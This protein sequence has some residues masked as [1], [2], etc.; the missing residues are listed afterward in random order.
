MSRL[1]GRSCQDD[2]YNASLKLFQKKNQ[3][4]KKE[5]KKYFDASLDSN[6]S[7]GFED[8]NNEEHQRSKQNET[9]RSRVVSL[10]NSNSEEE[11][12]VKSAFNISLLQ[13]KEVVKGIK[14]D[15][16]KND[17]KGN[18]DNSMKLKLE[19]L[20]EIELLKKQKEKLQKRSKNIQE[21]ISKE[22]RTNNSPK[23]T[24]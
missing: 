2:I 8:L 11:E 16:K 3:K 22:I 17:T 9:S 21:R 24:R 15:E 19:V 18:K 1:S 13:S 7:I 4:E 6:K 20:R 12:H 10:E 5:P 23:P 14:K